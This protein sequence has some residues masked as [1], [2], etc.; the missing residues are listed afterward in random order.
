MRRGR[1]SVEHDLGVGDLTRTSAEPST[2]TWVRVIGNPNVSKA[3]SSSAFALIPPS[4]TTVAPIIDNSLLM[5]TSVQ[6]LRRL[7]SKARDEFG[8]T[9]PGTSQYVGQHLNAIQP[10]ITFVCGRIDFACP[11][12][13]ASDID[14]NHPLS[15]A[16]AKTLTHTE[17]EMKQLLKIAAAPAA[18]DVRV[19][20]GC[21]GDTGRREPGRVLP[22]G[23]RFGRNTSLDNGAMS[24]G[25][26]RTQRRLCARSVPAQQQQRLCLSAK[27]PACESVRHPLVYQ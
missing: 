12:V 23:I 17:G 18:A 8:Y 24:G 9:A 5:H 1:H 15:G 27:A 7:S 11:S 14:V 10:H 19:G 21:D 26:L 22:R 3:G 4:T 6:S 13:R 16:V 25:G 2:E 20:L